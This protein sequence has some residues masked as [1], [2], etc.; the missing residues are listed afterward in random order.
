MLVIAVWMARAYLAQLQH[1]GDWVRHTNDVIQRLNDATSHILDLRTAE[2][3]FVKTGNPMYLAQYQQ[4]TSDVPNAVRQTR[5][6][7][8]DN[9]PQEERAVRIVALSDQL[10]TYA[11]GAIARA[12]AQREASTVAP[13]PQPRDERLRRLHDKERE[14][15]RELLTLTRAMTEEENQLLAVRR[16]QARSALRKASAMVLFALALALALVIVATSA[17]TANIARR[18]KAQRE[19]EQLQQIV[20]L[21][22]LREEN[23]RVQEQFNGV[24]GHDLR[25]P[26]TA[27]L[28]GAATL[29]RR[30]LSETDAKTV[31]RIQ[32]SAERMRRMID[33][34]LDLTRIRSGG[35]IP[36]ERKRLDLAEVT[37]AVAEELE[38]AYPERTL[39][40]E[41]HGDT[42]GMW[43][44]DRLAQA[45]SNLV[46][47]ALEHGD[48]N[49]PVVV[50]VS[51]EP[52]RVVLAVHNS[53]DPIPKGLLPTLF[54]P[55]RR[56]KGSNPSGLGLGLFIMQQIVVAHDGSIDVES[57]AEGTT[58][59]VTFPRG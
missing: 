49:Q 2:R 21:Q 59:T 24:L 22:G 11:N 15:M 9:P 30:A 3:A 13:A 48:A 26:L 47:N 16:A 28:M 10:L 8:A 18:R 1:L 23:A 35:G 58:F 56:A 14:T 43:D 40:V 42:S 33:Q 44:P 39:Q 41:V 27:I 53:G 31:A 54:E 46:G 5:A 20:E 55:F 17:T 6:L 51:G 34:L 36:V 45:V 19:K 12:Q 25:N 37:R 52:E 4:A 57:T 29:Q 38:M 7:T 32:S 50:R